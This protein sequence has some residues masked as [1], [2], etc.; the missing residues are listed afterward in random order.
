VRKAKQVTA[1]FV[2]MLTMG[3]ETPH[4]L[5]PAGGFALPAAFSDWG[6]VPPPQTPPAVGEC[7]D[8]PPP[9]APAVFVWMLTMGGETPHP[10]CPAGGFALPAA[11]S[12]WGGVPPPQTP[13][14]VGGS[15]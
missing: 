9:Q 15:A 2:W 12:D 10:L 1:V 11:F 8:V 14:A 13:P 7:C 5:C 6:G 3:G 4:P